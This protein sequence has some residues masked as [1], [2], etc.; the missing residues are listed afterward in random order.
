MFQV[1]NASK[2]KICIHFKKKRFSPI[3]EFGRAELNGHEA[4]PTSSDRGLYWRK[5]VGIH[6]LIEADMTS[7]PH[8]AELAPNRQAAIR[9]VVEQLKPKSKLII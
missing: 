4:R 7:R 6:W 9:C 1:S 2:M 8:G 3:P 5:G